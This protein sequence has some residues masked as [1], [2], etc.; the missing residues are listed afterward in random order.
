VGKTSKAFVT[1]TRR[2]GIG[3]GP[4]LDETQPLAAE[5]D[6]VGEQVAPDSCG[7]GEGGQRPAE[8][9][10]RQIAVIPALMEPLEEALPVDLS[11]AGDAPVVLGD[12][13]VNRLGRTRG[14]R[15]GLI[16]LLDVGVE[17]VVHHLAIGMIYVANE[18]GGLCGRREEIDLEAVEV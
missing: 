15:A 2:R 12:V 8:R 17:A 14:D 6:G 9:L 16:L 10:D 3:S 7:R 18:A 1:S 4:R 13:Y 5:A 11:R